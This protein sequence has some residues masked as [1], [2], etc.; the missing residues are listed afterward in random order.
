MSS[1][2]VFFTSM[3]LQKE[4][5]DQ[6]VPELCFELLMEPW[7]SVDIVDY[8]FNFLIFESHVL[9]MQESWQIC[10]L[11][12]GLGTTTNNAAEYH[13]IILGLK[14]ALEMG[15]SSIKAMGDSKLVCM[16]VYL[17]THVLKSLTT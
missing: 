17:L 4:I 7:Y 13:A 10:R 11:R 3:V 2:P 12:Q 6:L 9:L 1:V 15:Y 5:Q 14:K 16:Q 8:K